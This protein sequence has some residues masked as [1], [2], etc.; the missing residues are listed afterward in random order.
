MADEQATGSTLVKVVAVTTLVTSL[1]SLTVESIWKPFTNYVVQGVS[2]LISGEEWTGIYNEPKIPE[3][4]RPQNRQDLSSYEHKNTINNWKITPNSNGEILGSFT[5]D[6]S[7]RK[8]KY[9]AKGFDSLNSDSRVLSFRGPQVGRG[10]IYLTKTQNEYYRGYAMICDCKSPKPVSYMVCPYVLYKD[11]DS[12]A[13]KA[14]QNDPI[15]KN[16]CTP[17]EIE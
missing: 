8:Y 2:S 7:G 5:E 10:T 6:D 17:H 4:R 15:L 9:E 11:S 12:G 16:K 14:A 1:V 3:E 13:A